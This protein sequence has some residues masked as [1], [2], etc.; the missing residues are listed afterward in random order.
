MLLI[1]KLFDIF[2]NKFI[3]FNKGFE[4][5]FL[6]SVIRNFQKKIPFFIK[7]ITK[8][9]RF[10]PFSEKTNFYNK[11]ILEFDKNYMNFSGI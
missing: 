2:N 7:N 4:V 5:V 8:K 1:R 6:I 11:F 9:F 10:F 3:I